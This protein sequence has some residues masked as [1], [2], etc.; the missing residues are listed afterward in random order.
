MLVV[1]VIAPCCLFTYVLARA[2]VVGGDGRVQTLLKTGL[3][4][5]SVALMLSASWVLATTVD[6]DWRA[7]SL[8]ALSAAVLY[9][10]R[11]HPLWLIAAGAIAGLAGFV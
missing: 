8:T 6:K 7:A 3:A 5:V 2:G 1:S 9:T 4:P 10:T 11:I